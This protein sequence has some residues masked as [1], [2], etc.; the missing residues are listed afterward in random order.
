MGKRKNKHVLAPLSVKRALLKANRFHPLATDSNRQATTTPSFVNDADRKNQERLPPIVVTSKTFNE[1]KPMIDAIKATK[2]AIKIISIGVKIQFDDE[3]EFDTACAYFQREKI[4]HFTHKKKQ[5][6]AFKAVM[7]GLPKVE[8]SEVKE[9]FENRLNI[10]PLAIFEIKSKNADP[11]NAIYLF[12]FNKKDISM[13]VLNKVKV[14]NHTIV[15]WA[16]YSPKF[17]G[18]TQCRVCTMYG[19]GAE[20]CNRNKVCCYCA[21]SDHESKNCGMCPANANTTANVTGAIYKCYSCSLQKLPSNHPATDPNCPARIQYLNI[22]KNMNARN[23]NKFTSANATK[24]FK[25][26]TGVQIEHIAPVASTSYAS[27]IKQ[28]PPNNDNNSELFSIPEL[29]N[30]FNGAV[31]QLSQCKTK[32]EQMK[33]IVSLL[34]YAVK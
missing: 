7:Y 13:E 1:V 18:P 31:A 14:V 32:I 30:I 16:P 6:K 21:S 28:P 17:K 34:E 33:V 19:H 11:N 4:E 10:V 3:K 2:F 15:K 5:D 8:T 9:Y 29:F 23:T 24:L 25:S 20:N 22:R 27:V 12:H 26:Q